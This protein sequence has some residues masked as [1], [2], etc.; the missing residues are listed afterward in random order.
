MPKKKENKKASIKR[1]SKKKSIK[2]PVIHISGVSGAGKTT[3]GYR[4]LDEYKDKIVIYNV[5]GIRR[6]FMLDTGTIETDSFDKKLIERYIHK[7]M[8]NVKVPIIFIGINGHGKWS[9]ENRDNYVFFNV[10]STH[11]FC[12][13]IDEKT[14]IRQKCHR[15]L[16]SVRSTYM[17]SLQT[18]S[19]IN[20]NDIFIRYIANDLL[21]S[22][23]LERIVDMNKIWINYY[24]KN[25]YKFMSAND[26]YDS[27]KVIIDKF[28]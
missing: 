19:L 13:D 17:T 8:K 10:N 20:S 11:N 5:D 14:L 15:F 6:Q 3:L 18:H 7:L 27:V 1:K 4:L 28:L 12:I 23:D 24:K 16:D 22:C 25:K 2:L 21:N 26:T 9:R